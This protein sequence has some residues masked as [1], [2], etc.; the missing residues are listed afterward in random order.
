MS[1]A[2]IIHNNKKVKTT[3]MSINR[4]KNKK[5]WSIIQLNSIGS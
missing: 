5:L 2:I 1:I 4:C 3:Q